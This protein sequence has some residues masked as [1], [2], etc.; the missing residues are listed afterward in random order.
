L[1]FDNG[2]SPAALIAQ[3]AACSISA[4]VVLAGDL[5]ANVSGSGASISG[6]ISEIGGS[7]A[8]VKTGA[9][10]LT[11]NGPTSYTGVST[12]QAGTLQLGPA[13]QNVVLQDAAHGGGAGADIQAGKLVLSYT[14]AGDDPATTVQGLLT[15]S[16]NGG[17]SPFATGQ[18]KIRLWLPANSSAGPTTARP[19]RSRFSRRCRATPTWIVR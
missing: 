10:T 16:Y 4:P 9:G 1:T 17:V 18:L 13:A 11:L 2:A 5:A 7:R 19:S 8:I 14:G 15:T 6:A 12:V 3:G